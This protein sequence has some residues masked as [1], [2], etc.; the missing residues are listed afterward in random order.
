MS[1]LARHQQA[2]LTLAPVGLGYVLDGVSYGLPDLP[3]TNL[4]ALAQRHAQALG[5]VALHLGSVQEQAQAGQAAALAQ[6]L[7][8]LAAGESL[9]AAQVALLRSEHPLGSAAV[10]IRT[11]GSADKSP[12]G[13]PLSLGYLLGQRPYAVN[14]LGLP[15]GQHEG[16]AEREAIRV[17]L[18]HAELLGYQR[19]NVLSDHKF[20]TRRYSEDLIYRGRR[21][22]DT[23][24]RLDALVDHLSGR[25]SFS[26]APNLDTD[27]PHRLALH[28]RALYRLAQGQTLSRTQAIAIRRVHFALKEL[29]Q[30]AS[31]EVLF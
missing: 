23:L 13:G 24:E 2:S 9:S 3:D 27:A 21:K 18:Q 20:H 7:H 22:S 1:T 4:A 26:Y 19:L 16:I 25:V 29:A 31:R 17:A 5:I 10:T 12:M 11:D 30:D 8:T 28:C 6:A 14:L 15:A